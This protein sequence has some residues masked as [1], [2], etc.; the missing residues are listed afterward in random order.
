VNEP[1]TSLD[2]AILV[3]VQ[4]GY[5]VDDDGQVLTSKGTVRSQ[6]VK[7]HHSGAYSSFTVVVGSRPNRRTVNVQVH[8]LAGY[9]KFGDQIFD[10][11]VLVYHKDGNRSNNST[12]NIVMGTQSDVMMDRPDDVKQRVEQIRWSKCPTRRRPSG[13]DAIHPGRG[14]GL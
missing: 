8:R 9:Q 11:S 12:G 3:A 2:K 10:K 14:G 13:V 7:H 5:R 6:L 1:Q 4:K